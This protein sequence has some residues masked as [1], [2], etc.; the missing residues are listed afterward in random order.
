MKGGWAYLGSTTIYSSL[1]CTSL[2]VSYLITRATIDLSNEVFF[3]CFVFFS[4]YG[5]NKSGEIRQLRRQ[6]YPK[7][8]DFADV[9]MVGPTIETSEFLQLC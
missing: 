3:F 9:C 8:L 2:M 7:S 4:S 6:S 5:I 1:L